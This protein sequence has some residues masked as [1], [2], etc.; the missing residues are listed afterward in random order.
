MKLLWIILLSTVLF[1]Q[2]VYKEKNTEL[3]DKIKVDKNTLK[4]INGIVKTYDPSSV[5]FSETSYKDGKKDGTFKLYSETGKKIILETPYK[6]GKE[7]GIEKAYYPAGE[8]LVETPYKDGKKDGIM[9]AYYENGELLEEI[10][11]ENNKAIRGFKYN[12]FGEK[13]K[14][15]NAHIYNINREK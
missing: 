6:D 11:F 4:P 14:M 5:L 1:S 7:N 15:T 9:K 3:V 2:N 12:Q 8:L 13:R 10:I